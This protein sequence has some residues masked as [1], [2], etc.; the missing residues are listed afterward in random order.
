MVFSA[1]VLMN[2]ANGAL[3]LKRKVEPR[4]VVVAIIGLGIALV[5]APE[6]EVLEGGV[7]TSTDQSV[8]LGLGFMLGTYTR[9]P[10]QHDINEKPASGF[11]RSANQC[12]RNGFMVALLLLTPDPGQR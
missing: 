6:F 5:F 4:A 8:I 1:I 12:L 3:F 9:L 7:A 2:I 10:G 11:A